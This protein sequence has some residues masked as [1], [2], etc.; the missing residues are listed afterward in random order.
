MGEFTPWMALPSAALRFYNLV[1]AYENRGAREGSVYFAFDTRTVGRPSKQS[2]KVLQVQC[3]LLVSYHQ[4]KIEFYKTFALCQGYAP[5][6]LCQRERAEA[7]AV[8]DI[9]L[10]V[11]CAPVFCSVALKAYEHR[12]AF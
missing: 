6:L 10:E 7:C 3:R 8:D 1:T 2:R 5:A 4:F 11:S 12:G 9:T